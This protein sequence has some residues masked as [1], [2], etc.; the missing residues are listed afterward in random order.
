MRNL[1]DH[2][3]RPSQVTAL[4]D[5]TARSFRLKEGATLSDLAEL[6][7]RIEA[8]DGRKPLFVDV[9]FDA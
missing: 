2:A 1:S 4:F 9:K 6:F 5:D 3:M 8:R 7:A